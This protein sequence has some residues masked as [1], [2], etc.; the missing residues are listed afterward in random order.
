MELSSNM[1]TPV[2][3]ALIALLFVA[4]SVRA[5]RLRHRFS[6]AVGSGGE[7]E[8]ERAI[9]AHANCAE[10][11]PIALLLVFFLEVTTELAVW[12]HLLGAR[13]LLGR[14]VH[15]YGISQVRENFAFR[16]L[17]MAMTFTVIV[18]AAAALLVDTLFNG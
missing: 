9:R 14:L 10:Y 4:L 5:L 18:G 13:L 2:Y 11:V 3:A 16:I 7:P 8:L 6:V 17:G 15:A 12:I 1:I